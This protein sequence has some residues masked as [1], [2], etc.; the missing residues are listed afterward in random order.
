MEP[1]FSPG[2]GWSLLLVLPAAFLLD[3]VVGDPR[4]LPHPIRWMGKAIESAEP[5]CRAL[6]R[7][8]RQAGLLFALLLIGGTWLLSSLLLGLV[9]ALHPLAGFVL[10]VIML[11]YCLS[12]RSLAQAAREIYQL[13]IA[14]EVDRAR[15]AVAMIVGRDVGSYGGDDIARAT[16][17]TVAENFVDGVLSP[18]FFAALGGGPL[19][20]CYKMVN[21]LDSMVGYKNERYLDFGRAAARID[22]LANFLPARGAVAVISLAAQLSPLKSGRLAWETGRLEGSQHASPNAGYPE[23]AFAGALGVRLNGPNYYGGK[24]VDKPFIGKLFAPPKVVH[25]DRACSLMMRASA[26]GCLLAWLLAWLLI[27]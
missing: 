4:G 16:V 15:Q 12:A 27:L 26:L 2:S 9:S 10:E 18:L 20:L 13:L 7:N 11:F 25:I 8:P 23:A 24:L 5:P 21:T 14:G 1:F 17:E 3:S 6:V 22:D 19:A